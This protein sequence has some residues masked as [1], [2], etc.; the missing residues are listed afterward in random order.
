MD[1]RLL[2]IRFVIVF[3]IKV[4]SIY[5]KCKINI[6]LDFKVIFKINIFLLVFVLN[7]MLI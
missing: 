4:Y 1:F 2:K 7:F 3:F 5:F 6:I